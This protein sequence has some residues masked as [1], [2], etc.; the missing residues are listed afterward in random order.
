MNKYWKV[1]KK[2]PEELEYRRKL[3]EKHLKDLENNQQLGTGYVG[4]QQGNFKI[5]QNPYDPYAKNYY[6]NKK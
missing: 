2:S 5:A 6:K 3:Q 4:I 1:T